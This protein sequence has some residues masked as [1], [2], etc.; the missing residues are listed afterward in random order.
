MNEFREVSALLPQRG[1]R[2][3]DTSHWARINA[4]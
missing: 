3:R 4:N 2:A 1:R